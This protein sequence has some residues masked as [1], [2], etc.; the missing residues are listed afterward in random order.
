MSG[1]RNSGKGHKMPLR[2]KIIFGV[3]ALVIV[4]SG[5]Y[6]L[7]KKGSSVS[8]D[9]VA[10]N[11]PYQKLAA[12]KLAF[13]GDEGW[14]KD[15]VIVAM[16]KV[17]DAHT[18][19]NQKDMD[20]EK[21]SFSEDYANLKLFPQMMIPGMGWTGNGVNPAFFSNTAQYMV[22]AETSSPYC[23][24]DSDIIPM[25]AAGTVTTAILDIQCDFSAVLKNMQKG[26]NP[27]PTPSTVI[28]PS[29][30]V[31]NQILQNQAANGA[32]PR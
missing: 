28:A 26:L 18:L 1:K 12:I 17:G 2:T 4:V 30:Q 19:P 14:I 29:P 10:P 3:A 13:E 20:T 16:M 9:M 11:V 6:V 32:G 25:P 27:L 5:G 7:A 21:Y 8:A 24:S 15:I 31:Q 23:A 22:V